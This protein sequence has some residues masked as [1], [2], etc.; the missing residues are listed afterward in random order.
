MKV[1]FTKHAEGK[2]IRKDI[3]KFKVTKKLIK[4][5]VTKSNHKN[6]T[7]YGEFAEIGAISF[8]H[9]VRVIY[10]I[11]ESEIIIITFHIAKKGR[12]ET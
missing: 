7:K 5:I 11:I 9:I 4:E 12:Y 1:K 10:D 6:R 2:L 3:K 8:G